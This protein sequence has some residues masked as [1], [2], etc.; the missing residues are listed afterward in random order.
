VRESTRESERARIEKSFE[1]FGLSAEDRAL[2]VEALDSDQWDWF[3]DCD[4]CTSVSEVFWP[5]K[6][7]PPCV[8]HDF[9]CAMG[10]NGLD[11]SKRFFRLQMAYGMSWARAGWRAAGVTVA[12]YGWLKWFR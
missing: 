4:G 1:V 9:D 5:T 12:W 11:A 10:K 7:F 3:G 2:I 6:Y 8:R